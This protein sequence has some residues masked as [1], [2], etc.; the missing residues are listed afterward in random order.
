MALM[1]EQAREQ[2]HTQVAE[3]AFSAVTGV[4]AEWRAKQCVRPFVVAWS[5][6]G[7]TGLSVLGEDLPL[8][9]SKWGP[10]VRRLAQQSRACALLHVEQQSARVLMTFETPVG[11][12]CKALPIKSLGSSLILGEPEEVPPEKGHLL[13]HSGT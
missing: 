10:C 3:E 11:V 2:F 9:K 4:Y 5:T 13:W 7:S 12:T 6:R 1:D 8:E